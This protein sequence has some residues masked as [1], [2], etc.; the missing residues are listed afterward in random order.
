MPLTLYHNKGDGTFTDVSATSGLDKFTGRALGVVAIDMNDDGWVD[1]FVARDASPNLLLINNHNGTF[2]DA[3]L[4]AEVAYDQNGMAK[5]GM[6][7]D[8]GD[9]DGDGVPDFVVTNFS[10]AYQHHKDSNNNYAGVP[11]RQLSN[12]ALH[13]DL[14]IHSFQSWCHCASKT[15][16]TKLFAMQPVQS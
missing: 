16:K 14:P 5:A 2:E 3:A 4:D 13:C 15:L 11:A 10:S 7:V 12:R 6:G 8:A 1:L 9:I